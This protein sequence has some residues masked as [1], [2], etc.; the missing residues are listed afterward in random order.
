[1]PSLP[2]YFDHLDHKDAEH[3]FRLVTAPARNYLNTSFTETPSSQKREARPRAK[4]HPEA[5]AKL[6]IA[7]GCTIRLGN[8]LG[9]L[10]IEAELFDGLQADVVVV[11]SIWPNS[12]FAE[13]IGINLL[14]SA[15]PGL[16]K[17]GAVFHDTAIWVRAE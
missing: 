9:S 17:G 10:L 6:G 2:G 13:G 1:M 11:E 3:P 4:L 16:P 7:D 14:V 12:A 8:R 15:E 5:A